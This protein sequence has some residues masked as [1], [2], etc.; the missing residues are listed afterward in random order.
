MKNFIITILFLPLL[1]QAQIEPH[2]YRT[3]DTIIQFPQNYWTKK[4]MYV[5]ATISS[6]GLPRPGLFTFPGLGEQTNNPAD[7]QIYGPHYW[8]AHGWDSS[9]RMGNGVHY[10]NYFTIH[11]NDKANGLS[12]G[13]A[14]WAID[15]LCKIYHVNRKAVHLAGL[16]MGAWAI[17]GIMLDTAMMNLPT[18]VVCLS[19]SSVM[20]PGTVGSPMNGHWAKKYGGKFLGLVGWGDNAQTVHPVAKAVNDSVPGSGYAAFETLAGGGHGGWNSMYAPSNTHWNTIT[21]LGPYITKGVF[22]NMQGSYRDGQSIFQWMLAQGDT[23]MVAPTIPPVAGIP[24]AVIVIDSTVIHWPN[25]R[26]YLTDSSYVTNGILGGIQW[27][28]PAGPNV[29][30]WTSLT[31]RGMVVSGLIP[32]VYQVKLYAEDS[33]TLTLDTAIIYFKVLG[34][35]IPPCPICPPIRNAIGFT[36]DALTGKFKFTYDDGNP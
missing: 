23:S 28:Q 24:H 30:I 32:G 4:P 33:A 19:G 12:A 26:V 1:A 7:N 29:A 18:S 13:M 20:A 34:P 35:V 11:G 2:G 21:P 25:T 31:G 3:I 10:P 36:I 15:T 6:D 22:P 9:I 16:S 14:Y 5:R 8:M 17:A 27:T